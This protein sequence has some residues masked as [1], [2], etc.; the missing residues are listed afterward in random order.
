MADKMTKEQRHRCMAHIR[1]KNTKPEMTVR[2]YLFARGFR[3]RLHV[4]R[5]P[6]TPDIVLHR[7]ATVI[8][9]HGCFWHGHDDCGK[10]RLPQTNVDFWKAKIERNKARDLEDYA[11]LHKMGWHVLVVWECQLSKQQSGATLMALA[12]RLSQIYLMRQNAKLSNIDIEPTTE[13]LGTS[14]EMPIAAEEKVEYGK[15]P[16]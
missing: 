12:R 16:K 6:G 1:S 4:R 13:S 2:K 5:L 3:Y 10:F 9:V 8:F 15:S 14:S 7:Y 11:K